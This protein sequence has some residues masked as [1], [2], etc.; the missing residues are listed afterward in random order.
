MFAFGNQNDNGTLDDS[1]A[2]DVG[3]LSFNA[4]PGDLGPCKPVEFGDLSSIEVGKN[5]AMCGFP[6]GNDLLHN[7]KLGIDR[8]GPV[9]HNGMISALAPY[10]TADKRSIQIFLT[11]INTIGGLSGS[12]VFTSDNGRVIGLHFAGGSQDCARRKSDIVD[13][14]SRNHFSHSLHLESIVHISVN[15]S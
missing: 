15:S 9:V 14:F 3:L 7:P 6:L 1:G 13:D 2:L 4:K 5:I 10:D 11:D 8:F 12:P